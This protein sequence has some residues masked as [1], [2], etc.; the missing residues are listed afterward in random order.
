MR[1]RVGHRIV[2]EDAHLDVIEELLLDRGLQDA[3]IDRRARVLSLARSN[4]FSRSSK[5][6]SR[7]SS[8][9]IESRV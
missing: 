4:F 3:E 7:E 8:A 2:L 1:L 5:R 6:R 9:S